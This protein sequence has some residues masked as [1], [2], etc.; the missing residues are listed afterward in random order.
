MHRFNYFCFLCYRVASDSI[1]PAV[2]DSTSPEPP[3]DRFTR[4]PPLRQVY[5]LSTEPGTNAYDTTLRGKF[6]TDKGGGSNNNI[7]GDNQNN[8]G[9][10]QVDYSD[11]HHDH[12]VN[13]GAYPMTP[14]ICVEGGRIEFVKT[15]VDGGMD[16][17]TPPSSPL[18][19]RS[20]R[21]YEE[22]KFDG[23]KVCAFLNKKKYIP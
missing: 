22:E 12:L 17:Q 18:G 14:N 7:K 2:P 15:A 21:N 19:A 4:P 16:V 23:D 6:K 1:R 10:N 13:R 8:K 11:M 5:P 9:A 3:P 20:M